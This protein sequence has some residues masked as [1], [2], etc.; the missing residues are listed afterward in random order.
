MKAFVTGS[1]GLVGNNLV[2]EL[3][4]QGW[5]VK[6]LARS[7]T[8][9]KKLLGNL[10]VEIIT[11][12]MENVAGFAQHLHD[13]EVVFH[14]AAYFREYY[15]SGEADEHWKKLLRINVDATIELLRESEARGV[16][17]VIYVSSGGVIGKTVDGKPGDESTPADAEIMQNLY[18]KSKVVGEERIAEFLKTSSLPVVLILPGAIFGPGDA[19]PTASG[20]LIIDALQGDLPAVP[21]GGFVVVDV[22]DVAEAMIAAVEKGRSGERYII[23]NRY[24]SI[25]EIFRIL[26]D[27]TGQAT[28]RLPLPVPVAYIYAW[29]SETW[30]KLSN[31]EPQATVSAIR[32]L[33]TRRDVVAD[34][35]I[36]EL[37]L[38]PRPL[39]ETLRAEV[40]WF[41]DHGYFKKSLPR[42]QPILA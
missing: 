24:I 41:L 25:G 17:K 15:G 3:V 36:R 37:G 10:D 4:A 14:T 18:F 13:C 16:S 7:A 33:T 5:E 6:A 29:V 2:R 20:Q 9:A 32:T 19:A 22:R 42:M 31:T 30:G 23:T 34:K 11:G 35:A 8:K 26:S 38:S 28:P 21:P 1:T 27:V 39:E 40:Q 12:D